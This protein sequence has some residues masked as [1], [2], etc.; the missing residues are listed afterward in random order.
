MDEDF[1]INLKIDNFGELKKNLNNLKCELFQYVVYSIWCKSL[2][3][4]VVVVVYKFCCTYKSFVFLS[5]KALTQISTAGLSTV[6]SLT[7][8]RNKPGLS[9]FIKIPKCVGPVSENGK[10]E[11]KF[12]DERIYRK[13]LSRRRLQKRGTK[14]KCGRGF[15]H[16]PRGSLGQW[17]PETECLR[18]SAIFVSGTSGMTSILNYRS[19]GPMY[20]PFVF[21]SLLYLHSRYNIITS[22]V[23]S[24]LP[25]L[26]QYCTRL[27]IWDTTVIMGVI[28]DD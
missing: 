18:A 8:R 5:S 27:Q 12:E 4:V 23:R 22:M 26:I 1:D 20:I 10:R 15:E 19:A 25:D 11:R 14:L 7:K 6:Y 13:F 2:I 9:G 3:V 16:W 28:L 21:E 17:V 24:H